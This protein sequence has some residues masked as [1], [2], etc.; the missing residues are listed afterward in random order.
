MRHLYFYF[1]ADCNQTKSR[2]FRDLLYHLLENREERIQVL[3][4]LKQNSALNCDR[5]LI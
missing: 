1:T 5:N 2:F 3:Q 4:G